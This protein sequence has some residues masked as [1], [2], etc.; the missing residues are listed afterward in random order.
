MKKTLI[1]ICIALFLAVLPVSAAGATVKDSAALLTD[2]ELAAIEAV[3]MTSGVRYFVLTEQSLDADDYPTSAEVLSRCGITDKDSSVILVLRRAS[4]TYYYDMYTYGEAN[5][6]F[7]NADI[8]RV[9]DDPDVYDNIKGGR[10]G[11]GA[12]AFLTLCEAH[13]VKELTPTPVWQGVLIGLVIGAAVGGLAVLGVYLY[14]RR[15]LHGETYPLD[16]Y[17]KMNLTAHT[18]RFAGSFVTRTRV[19][20]NSS[21]GGSGGGHRGGR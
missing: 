20:S 6:L 21:S 14:Y 10:L 15:P 18:D 5:S 19:S 1:F 16:R 8:D 17:A 4:A 7:S 9:L 2:A 11:A 12:A 13:C 3:E